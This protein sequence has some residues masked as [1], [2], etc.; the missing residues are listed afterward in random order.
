MYHSILGLRVIKRKKK[1]ITIKVAV[2]DLTEKV[3]VPRTTLADHSENS[4]TESC[5]DRYS[6]Q[7]ENSYFTE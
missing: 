7:F 1:R 3:G 5:T 4:Q 6:S 2:G